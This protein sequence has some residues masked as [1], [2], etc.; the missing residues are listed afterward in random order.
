[1]TNETNRFIHGV[2]PAYFQTINGSDDRKA[3][4]LPPRNLQYATNDN[5]VIR[6]HRIK[7]LNQQWH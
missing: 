2:V 6:E 4:R 1:M 7:R 3:H 5:I